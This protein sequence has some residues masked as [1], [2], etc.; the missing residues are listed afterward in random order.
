LDTQN[1]IEFLSLYEP[2]HNQLS[3]FCRAISG[4]TEDGEDLLQD[5]IL[6]CIEGFN[7]IKDKD[8]FKSYLFSIACN[9]HKMK[10]RRLKFRAEFSDNE[11]N[12][13]VDFGQ[14]QEYLT[15]FRIVYEKMLS[16]PERM[17]ETLILY[18]I[19][20][21]S[22]EEIQKIQGGSLSGVKLRLKRGREKLLSLLNTKAQ[23]KSCSDAFNLL[24]DPS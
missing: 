10:L 13:I 9:L 5:T 11:I 3:K 20:D 23:K 19:S 1:K 2:V 12:Q 21:L 16:L 4:N 8:V 14:D 6:N 15:D 22:L 24:K 7:K 17:A 18:H